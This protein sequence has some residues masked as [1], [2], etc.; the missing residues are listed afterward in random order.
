MHRRQAYRHTEHNVLL[1]E[2]GWDR[3]IDR[4]KH[5]KTT[6]FYKMSKGLCQQYLTNMIS[7]TAMNKHQHNLRNR[8]N[9]QIPNIG[10]SIYTKLFMPS[11]SKIWNTLPLSLC[12]TDRLSTFK[13]YLS[14]IYFPP[15]V[16]IDYN[17]LCIGENGIF[18]TRIR[19]GLSAL[20]TQRC[21]YNLI[22][23]PSCDLCTQ[24]ETPLHYFIYCPG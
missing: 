23:S 19:L 7:P 8:N 21:K 9:R 2:L 16:N 1:K 5:H 17:K 13:N 14:K 6:L 22:D 24:D 18:L 12:N 4:A 15:I 3:L 20:N 10:L 11:A